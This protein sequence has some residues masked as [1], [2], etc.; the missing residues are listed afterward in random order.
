MSNSGRLHT[1]EQSVSMRV[2]QRRHLIGTDT[3]KHL[4]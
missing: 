3:Y 1:T 4:T 2:G